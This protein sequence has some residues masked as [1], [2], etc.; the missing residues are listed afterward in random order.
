LQ[1][2]LIDLPAPMRTAASAEGE[3]RIPVVEEEL[4]VGKRISENRW[5]RKLLLAF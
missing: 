3:V 1:S 4:K 5:N 2:K